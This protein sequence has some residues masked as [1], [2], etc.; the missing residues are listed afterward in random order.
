[1]KKNQWLHDLLALKVSLQVN[2]QY[3]NL[4]EMKIAF[5]SCEALAFDHSQGRDTYLSR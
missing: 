3:G 5:L 4:F 1:M 2:E